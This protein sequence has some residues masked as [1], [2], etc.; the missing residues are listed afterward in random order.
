MDAEKCTDLSKKLK[1]LK[2]SY[3]FSNLVK[4][5]GEAYAVKDAVIP[6][7]CKTYTAH[8]AMMIDFKAL[9]NALQN[10][11]TKIRSTNP[12]T[13]A[14]DL[15]MAVALY[16]ALKSMKDVKIKDIDSSH[17]K[18]D[19]L[20]DLVGLKAVIDAS[21][22]LITAA[23]AAELIALISSIDDSLQLKTLYDK[24]NHLLQLI[25]NNVILFTA[26]DENGTELQKAYHLLYTAII[27]ADKK[28]EALAAAVINEPNEDI[29]KK[30]CDLIWKSFNSSFSKISDAKVGGSLPNFMSHRM[31]DIKAEANRL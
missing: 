19:P 28:F 3:D 30:N 12:I 4:A 13:K 6:P 17:P 29:K 31:S 20:F 9:I 22:A 24:V 2:H 11:I 21:H 16:D 18:D 8:T 26:K 14:E 25:P 23:A 27:A 7:S 10:H 5:L 15:K 1:N